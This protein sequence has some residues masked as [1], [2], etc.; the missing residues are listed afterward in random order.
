MFES[1]KIGMIMLYSQITMIIPDWLRW[2][3]EINFFPVNNNIILYPFYYFLF[4]SF[5][6]IFLPSKIMY[7]SKT[8][9]GNIPEYRDNGLLAWIITMCLQYF[10]TLTISVE[11]RQ[12][13]IQDDLADFQKI[14]NFYGICVPLYT[15]YNAMTTKFPN[16]PIFS[17]SFIKDFYKGV[18]L[19]P[20]CLFGDIK[21][22]INSRFGMMLWGN[23]VLMTM[24]AEDNLAVFTSGI[25]QLVYITKFFM[26]ESGYIKTADITLDRAGYYLLWGCICY[27]P[28]FY[29]VP[30]LY[31]YYNPVEIDPI[32]SVITIIFGISSIFINYFID[33]QRTKLRERKI[34]GEDV[35]GHRFIQAE[36]TTSDNKK[37]KTWLL[38][39]GYWGIARNINYLFEILSAFSWTAPGYIPG[40]ILCYS[41]LIF[42]TVLLVHRTYRID[43]KCEEKYKSAWLHY[44]ILV[45]YK[46]L[47]G[48]F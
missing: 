48:F 45:P 38:A 33:I 16:E 35:Y 5:L 40:N 7:G 46:I 19:H 13:C 21:L 30:I 1:F 22:L 11:D 28:N 25:I 8:P 10:Y 24:M 27:V 6:Y 36:Y 42:L 34:K 12:I 9:G 47:P 29:T 18:E 15:L 20:Q 41:Y 37:H 44:K 14:L 32:S 26:W 17:G 4:Q 43:K 39:S 3:G 2:S 31:H 23:I